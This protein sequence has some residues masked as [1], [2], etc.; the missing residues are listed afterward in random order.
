MKRLAKDKLYRAISN[1]AYAQTR[2]E[3]EM[4][5]AALLEEAKRKL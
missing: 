1:H 3:A 4:E 2:Y 5:Q